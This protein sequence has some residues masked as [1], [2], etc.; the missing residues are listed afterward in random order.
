MGLRPSLAPGLRCL[1]SFVGLGLRH[2]GLRT[3]GSWRGLVD[4]ASC[5]RGAAERSFV[6]EWCAGLRAP[7]KWPRG[8]RVEV[9]QSRGPTRGAVAGAELGAE[10]GWRGG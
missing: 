1:P 7:M 5:H 9:R 3:R 10:A 2:G 4:D 8:V 6:G